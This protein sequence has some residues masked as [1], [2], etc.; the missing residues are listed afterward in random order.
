METILKV[1][2][3]TFKHIL[4]EGYCPKYKSV[5]QFTNADNQ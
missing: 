3:E 1:Y 5:S 2:D 4:N